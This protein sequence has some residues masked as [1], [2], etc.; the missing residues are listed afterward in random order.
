MPKSIRVGMSEIV[1][2]ETP[3]ILVTLGLGS[4]I[5]VCV[6]DPT[7]KVGGMAHVML[8]D[9]STSK[10]VTTRGK[11]ADTAIPDLIELMQKK[12]AAKHRMLVKMAGGAQMF[13]YPGM[14]PQM[15][16][17]YRN[18][19]A[20]EKALSALGLR[21]SGKSIGGHSGR[22]IYMDLATG[23]VKVRMLNSPEIIL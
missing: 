15:H 19:V 16:I 4:C 9:S 11:F 2:A 21:V 12:G 18:A 13:A 10:E 6:Y 22:S 7:I 14:S 20:V 8:P 23:T 1:V 5:G 3:D 17:G